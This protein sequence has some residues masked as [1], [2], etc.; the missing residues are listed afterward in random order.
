MRQVLII[1][2][3]I[4]VLL[5]GGPAQACV[6]NYS[7]LAD[8]P[9]MAELVRKAAY[10]E[11]AQVV[12]ATRLS[13][14]DVHDW[15]YAR[16][17]HA[18]TFETIE[19][20]K[21][22]DVEAFT[23]YASDPA[24]HDRP[25]EC[26]NI[27]TAG[28]PPECDRASALNRVAESHEERAKA[29]HQDPRFFN[30]VRNQP[31]IAYGDVP[32]QPVEPAGC[33]NRGTISLLPG[34]TYLVFRDADGVP[35]HDGL[36]L[37]PVSHGDDRWLMAVR[38][39]LDHPE[40]DWLEPRPVRQH[41]DEADDFELYPLQDCEL[42]PVREGENAPQFPVVDM[43]EARMRL[44]SSGFEYEACEDADQLLITDIARDAAFFVRDGIVDFSTIKSQYEITGERNVPLEEVLGW[45]EAD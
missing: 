21:G 22:A 45:L 30:W 33:N 3:A 14:E 10:V 11:L 5:A 13:D 34:A 32:E 43:M 12:S 2:A 42:E 23:L 36:N 41:I 24:T 8:Q 1:G 28:I 39:L 17:T 18:Y 27:V 26:A 35:L 40:R 38:Y 15:E 37:E 20:L 25:A 4:G 31:R 19:T 6:R 7:N 16:A 9:L 44:R 29:R